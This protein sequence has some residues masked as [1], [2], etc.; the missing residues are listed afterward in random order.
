M[1]DSEENGGLG[2]LR[3]FTGGGGAAAFRGSER[4]GVGQRERGLEL[5]AESQFGAHLPGGQE[6]GLQETT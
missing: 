4:D 6:E 1:R 5:G 2:K 3:A